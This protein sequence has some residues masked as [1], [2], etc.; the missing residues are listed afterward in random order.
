MPILGSESSFILSLYWKLRDVTVLF[1]D[2]TGNV[3]NRPYSCSYRHR[4]SNSCEC[5]HICFSLGLEK[6]RLNKYDFWN[7]KLSTPNVTTIILRWKKQLFQQMREN[8][9]LCHSIS[10]V[11]HHNHHHVI[12]LIGEVNRCFGCK[13]GFRVCCLIVP[14]ACFV[15]LLPQTRKYNTTALLTWTVSSYKTL[16]M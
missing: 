3:F 16:W 9:N 10:E 7:C 8:T 4:L 1:S 11:R 14:R 13:C 12:R 2:R 15:D 6:Y 5:L